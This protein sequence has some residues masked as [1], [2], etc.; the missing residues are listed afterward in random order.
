MEMILLGFSLTMGLFALIGIASTRFATRE[1]SDYLVAGRSTSAW[2]AGLSAVASNNSGFMFIG[3][4]GFSYHY[5]LS[6]FWLFFAW[7]LGDYISWRWVHRELRDRS[8]RQANDGITSFLSHDGVKSDR[9]FEVL[10]GVA[11]IIFLTLYA[12][13]QLKAGSKAIESTLQWSPI[14]GALIGAGLVALYSYAGGIR[15]SMWTDTAQAFVMIFAMSALVWTCHVEI[16]PISTLGERL[17]TIDPMLLT[18]TPSDATLGLTLNALGWLLAGFGGVGQPH[19]IVRVMTLADPNKIGVMRRVYFSW[20]IVFSALTMLVGLFARVYFHDQ[21][22]LS[23][24]KEVALPM[25]AQAYL[26]PIWVGVILAGIFAATISTADSQVLASSA[27]LT[28]DIFTQYRSSYT[29]SKL[30]TLSVVAVSLC[31][32]LA[33]PASVF[34]L[35]TLAWGLMM[36]C[37]APLMIARVCRWDLSFEG[38]LVACLLGV[39][40]MLVWKYSLGLGDAVYEGAV[41]FVVSMPIITL[42]GL[43]GSR[44]SGI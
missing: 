37:F 7:I 35:V 9:R 29:A 8:E 11:T 3:A 5:G 27:S 24:D 32:A 34:G 40:A 14:S 2:V 15:A 38:Y 22:A 30:A 6:A 41:G 17:Y 19:I 10:I 36:T 13:A 4:I 12:A 26:A 18:W 42:L 39:G 21:T 20:Y 43:R 23:F 1:V 31:V 33:G 16:A 25:L 44:R 28:Q